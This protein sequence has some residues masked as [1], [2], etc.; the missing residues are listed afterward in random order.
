MAISEGQFD[1]WA[2]QG[3]KVT[4]A[5][6][7]QS[8]T[9]VLNDPNSP[10]YPKLFTT[11]L[12]GSY[13]NDTNVWR[14][15]D[16]DILMRLNSTYYYENNLLNEGA[17][18]AFQ[19]NFVP[20]EYGFA[21][22]RADVT[23]WLQKKYGSAVKPGTK[24]IFIEGQGSRRDADVLV[25]A[26]YRRYRQSSKGND[27]DYDEGIFFVK[28]DGTRLHNF[29]KQHSANLT[30]KHQATNSWL[31]PVVRIF[32]NMRNRM[33]DSNLIA[34]GLAP[35]YFIEGL[36][37]NVPND[38]FGTSYEATVLAAL[39]WIVATDKTKLACASD[40][41]WLVRENTAMCWATED[42]EMFIAE[43]VKFWNNGGA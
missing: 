10:Y 9:A 41:H 25:S 24:A 31:K 38:L 35:S 2:A 14:D 26:N 6:T 32:K 34:A 27:N 28:T 5:A 16:V 7:Y 42:Y 39:K 18:A 20:A 29:P 13:G 11:F 30:T 19:K 36:V 40:L 21:E 4:S 43:L 15:S 23:G 8:I 33:V 22:F 1:T 12:Q 3:A 17:K 37:W